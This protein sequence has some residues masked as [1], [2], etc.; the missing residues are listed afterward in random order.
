[1]EVYVVFVLC[2]ELLSPIPYDAQARSVRSY[3][4][5]LEMYPVNYT[6]KI[7]QHVMDEN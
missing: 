2:A 6:K 5:L 3:H 7:D 4:A 1:M